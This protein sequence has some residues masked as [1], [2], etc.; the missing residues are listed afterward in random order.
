MVVRYLSSFYLKSSYRN[1]L[2]YYRYRN[3]SGNELHKINCHNYKLVDR[4][5]NYY[6]ITHTQNSKGIALR[7]ISNFVMKTDYFGSLLNVFML[8]R[9]QSFSCFQLSRDEASLARNAI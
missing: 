7:E 1:R 4:T 8:V 9:A 2:I 5:T 6:N 3:H